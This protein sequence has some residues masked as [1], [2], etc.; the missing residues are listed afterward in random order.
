MCENCKNEELREFEKRG[1]WI[2]D[3][4]ASGDC[5]ESVSYGDIP[6]GCGPDYSYCHKCRRY[7]GNC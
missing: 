7:H 4:K 5:E 6:R 1:G 2:S 3:G